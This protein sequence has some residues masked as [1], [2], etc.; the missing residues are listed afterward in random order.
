MSSSFTLRSSS[1]AA[2]NWC[3]FMCADQVQ[4]LMTF[5]IFKIKKP[6]TGSTSQTRINYLLIPQGTAA[7]CSAHH[8]EQTLFC[9]CHPLKPLSLV[10][11][12]HSLQGR[13]NSALAITET[14]ALSTHY[15]KNATVSM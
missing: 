11:F 13:H 12:S 14:A 6:W 9:L 2:N 3:T 7:E 8:G 15:F 10:V 5:Y 4:D 1:A